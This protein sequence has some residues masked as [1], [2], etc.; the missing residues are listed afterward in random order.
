LFSVEF[1]VVKEVV[2]D[3]F[4][5]QVG[6]SYACFGIE[7]SFVGQ[8]GIFD[9]SY[10]SGHNANGVQICLAENFAVSDFGMV[11]FCVVGYEGI[12]VKS[13]IEGGCVAANF[14]VVV[15]VAVGDSGV[16]VYFGVVEYAASVYFGVGINPT[17]SFLREAF[18]I[19]DESSDVALFYV[20]KVFEGYH[21][22]KTVYDFDF[23]FGHNFI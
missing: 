18:V 19:F 22:R 4:F 23:V 20:G 21:P 6:V 17:V 14:G 11:D 8:C 10:V 16:A 5:A 1:R 15:Q 13:G 12:A 7:V 3:G 2:Y 9:V